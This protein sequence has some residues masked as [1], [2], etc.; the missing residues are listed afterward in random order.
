MSKKK[1][2]ILEQFLPLH[3]W[4]SNTCVCVTCVIWTRG[5]ANLCTESCSWCSSLLWPGSP[6][7]SGRRAAHSSP[8]HSDL[9]CTRN[10]RLHSPNTGGTSK[11][12][13][14]ELLTYPAVGSWRFCLTWE[15][16]FD[17]WEMTVA[18]LGQVHL[19]TASIFVSCTRAV[20]VVSGSAEPKTARLM[21][22]T[23]NRTTNAGEQREGESWRNNRGKV[24]INSR[25]FMGTSGST[26]LRLA[27]KKFKCNLI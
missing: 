3:L 10:L 4:P 18:T 25:S 16:N 11:P 5:V 12:K 15:L 9:S 19:L 1:L 6:P 13:I 27:L 8:R 14:R 26:E 2:T 23:S 22:G 24:D 20:R 7:S 17:C 21:E